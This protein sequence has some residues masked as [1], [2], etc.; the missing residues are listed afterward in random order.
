MIER[1]EL[2]ALVGGAA[3]AWPLRARAQAARKPVIGVLFHSNPEPTLSLFRKA[4]Q[5]LGYREAERLRC[6]HVEHH[7]ELGWLLDGVVGGFGA[8][9][10]A[11]DIVSGQDPQL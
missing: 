8:L 2:I 4:L 1:R 3:L 5:S 11:I 10:D 9:G 7:L 6:L